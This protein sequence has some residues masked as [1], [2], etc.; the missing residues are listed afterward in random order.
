MRTELLLLPGLLCDAR[1]WSA[2]TAALAD[3]AACSVPSLTEHDSIGAMADAVLRD[4]P[5]RFAVAGFSMGG[6]IALEL[7]A[8]APERVERLA[9]L[10]TNAGGITPMV[11]EQLVP[12]IAR[13]EAGDL[14]AYL[15]EAFPR[16]FAPSRVTDRTMHD[17]YVSM[18]RSIGAAAG[19]RQ[20]R[21][22]LSYA[23]FDADPAAIAV[24]TA[25]I[26]GRFDRRLPPDGQAAMAAR[27][28]GA[29]MQVIETSG[30]F[31]PIEAPDAVNDALRAWLTGVREG[32]ASARSGS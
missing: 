10:S 13:V 21:A 20:L 16:Y 32:I 19:T 2:Q 12:A 26:A 27:I 17:I 24:P 6:C 1:V 30:H 4:A 18:A 25:V 23:G 7:L 28:P 15:E 31:T 14:D 11:R 22:L 9:L 3:V 29:T 5:P 8:R